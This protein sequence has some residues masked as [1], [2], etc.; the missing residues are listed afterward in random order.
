MQTLQDIASHLKS[1][2]EGDSGAVPPWLNYLKEGI[3]SLSSQSEHE[4]KAPPSES[5]KLYMSIGERD[6]IEVAHPVP[7]DSAIKR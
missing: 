2:S 6:L 3:A 5:D 4:F 1:A 7:Q